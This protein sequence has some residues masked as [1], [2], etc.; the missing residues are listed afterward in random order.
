MLKAL[1]TLPKESAEPTDPMEHALPTEQ[2]DKIE[3][4]LAMLNNE[5]SD[6]KEK[7]EDMVPRYRE[8]AGSVNPARRVTLNIYVGPRA[9]AYNFWQS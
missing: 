6:H 1:P 4:L 5:S 2:I 7:R 3:P 9:D 8:S